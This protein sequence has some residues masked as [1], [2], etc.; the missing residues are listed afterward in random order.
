MILRGKYIQDIKYKILSESACFVDDITKTFG[1]FLGS[2]FQL[3]FTY[4]MRTLSFTK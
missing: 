1:A 3:L 4:K 2:E